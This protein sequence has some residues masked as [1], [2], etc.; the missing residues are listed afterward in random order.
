LIAKVIHLLYILAMANILQQYLD[1]SGDTQA[2][3][4]EKVGRSQASI[5]RYLIDLPKNIDTL[6]RL[7]K[8]TG[9]P[10]EKFLPRQSA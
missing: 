2:Q 5:S 10:L 9:H 7:S 3:L 1:D 4:G 8:A 6:D